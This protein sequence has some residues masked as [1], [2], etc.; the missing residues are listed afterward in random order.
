MAGLSPER[1]ALLQQLLRE[2][3]SAKAAP[4]ELRRRATEGPVPLSF[5]QQRLWFIDQL[6]PGT[7]TYNMLYTVRLRG[8]LDAGALRGAFTAL[9]ARHEVLRTTFESRDGEPAQVVH[10]PAAMR[11]PLADLGGLDAAAREGE[12]RRLARAEALRP[13]DLARGPLLR[14]TL[15]RLEDADHVLFYCMHHIV[16]DGWSVRLLVRELSA[17]HAGEA[18]PELP[19][20]YA[21][22]SLWQRARLTEEVV[23]SQVAYWRERLS[24]APPLLALPTD[25][26]P[27]AGQ[28][29]RAAG[30]SFVV[31]G[32]VAGALRALGR[33]EGATPFMVVL[34]AWQLLLSRYAGQDDVVVGTPVAGRTRVELEGLIG[35]F[36]NMLALRADLAGDPPV[37]G[38]LAR[39]REATLGAYAHQDLPFERVVDELRVERSLSHAPLFQAVFVL[40]PATAPE[41]ETVALEGVRAEAFGEGSANNPQF[42]DL[43]VADEGDRMTG[44]LHFRTAL[45]DAETARRMVEHFGV[46]LEAVAADP[47]RRLSAI[48]LLP[49]GEREQVLAGWSATDG[50]CGEGACVHTLFEE[51]VRRTPGA[52]ALVHGSERV[53]Y[54]ELD[55]RA[56]RLAGLLRGSGAGPEVRVGVCLRRTPELVAALLGV[57]KAGGAYVPLDPAYPRERIAGMV[58]DARVAV[59]LTESALR[60]RLPAGGAVLCVDAP[61]GPPAPGPVPDGGVRPGNL[62]Y[63]IFT[64]GS[65]GRPKGVMVAHRGVSLLLEWLRD[66]LTDEER[67]GVLAS[68]PVSFDVSVAEI[69]G[70][71]CWG[72]TLLLVENALALAEAG[73]G[74]VRLAVMVPTAAAELLRAGRIPAGVRSFNLAGE[75]LAPALAEELYA[76]GVERV[77]NLYGPTEDTVYST[78]SRVR[79]GAGRVAVGRPLP[80]RWAYVL[81]RHLQ[82]Q[83]VG[84]PGELYVA[85][86]GLARGYAHRPG[87][88]AERF[89]PCPFGPPGSRM[90]RSMDL[91]RWLPEGEIEY[92]GRT[93]HQ[94]K[95]RGFRIEP[96]EVE[97]ALREHPGVE[98]A[99]VVAREDAPGSGGRRLVGYVVPV[100]G[101]GPAVAD[102]RGHLAARLPEHMVPSAMVVLDALPLTPSGKVD[103]TALPAPERRAPAERYAAPRDVLELELA[104]S[105]EELLGVRPVGVTENFFALGG[106]SLLA[107]RVLARIEERTGRRLPLAALFSGATVERLAALLR[108][109]EA[110]MPASPLVEIQPA[111]SRRPLFLVHPAGGNVLCYAALGRHL[112]PDQP[113]FGLQSR[114]TGAEEAPGPTIEAMA[115]DYLRQVRGVQPSGPLRLGGWSMGGV[116]AFEMARRLASAG[117]EV[118]TLVL[119]DSALAPPGAEPPEHLLLRDFALHL[120]LPPERL[121]AREGE[122]S[123]PEP[124][125]GLE[126]LLRLAHEEGALPPGLT[127]ASLRGLYRVYRANSLA[128][129]RYRPGSYPGRAVLLRSSGPAGRS[130]LASGGGEWDRHVAAGVEVRPVPGDH[131]GMVREPHVADLARELAACLERGPPP[132]P[133]GPPGVP[134]HPPGPGSALHPS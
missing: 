25:R 117:E 84:V 34:A 17:L 82:P 72:G 73:A 52:V 38:L 58:E 33:R 5:A 112:G 51:Q 124:D 54:A 81:D 16:S 37:A 22:Y 80:H 31:G 125:A 29:E 60:G 94:V 68:T 12:A 63:V 74:E 4:Q 79:R 129:R 64:S 7:P 85:G 76:L 39:V 103:R 78:V 122:L 18:L 119:I 98:D 13:F 113:L 50:G 26:P 106:H 116:V 14:G 75:A 46:L 115:A 47:G 71:L 55:A 127:L 2:R 67:A 15:V 101:A 97:A 9:V 93:D 24:G 87:L 32:G 104:R 19:V 8:P 105:W 20:Q 56:D 11:L 96:G 21:D 88:T 128:L 114:G 110:P 118:E 43:K 108:R 131:F 130:A 49:P 44:R 45:F 100:P 40:G 28:S 99:V 134:G 107:V 27:G 42:L 62:A 90:Y 133:P 48:P 36:V 77:R 65:T 92:L 30:C 6:E 89:L 69:F 91:A 102:L 66:E 1:R 41:R 10:P 95:V 83:P 23:R 57:L 3:T 121:A 61:A 120:D 109:D 35:L 132:G 70:T 53:T 123:A 126:A 59:V 111:G 86:E